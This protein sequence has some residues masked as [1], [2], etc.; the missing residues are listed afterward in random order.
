M[1]SPVRSLLA[2]L[3][4]WSAP[5]AKML[6][7]VSSQ[8][9]QFGQ[10]YEVSFAQ[11]HQL[12]V[13]PNTQFIN[14]SG[15]LQTSPLAAMIGPVGTDALGIP[16]Q[17]VYIFSFSATTEAL[18]L[19]YSFDLTG[20]D[21]RQ[22]GCP[23]FMQLPYDPLHPEWCLVVPNRAS[24][25]SSGSIDIIRLQP[26]GATAPV[27]CNNRLY[28][29][30][31]PPG[32]N[33][34]SHVYSISHIPIVP[35]TPYCISTEYEGPDG[36]WSF[37][38]LARF[39]TDKFIV[40]ATGRN[41]ILDVYYGNT[42][43]SNPSR[44]CESQPCGFLFAGEHRKLFLSTSHN[45][46]V[47]I[48]DR[49][50]NDSEI[51]DVI[52]QIQTPQHGWD[53]ETPGGIGE[54]GDTHRAVVLEGA[55][56]SL[57]GL[58]GETRL[59]FFSNNTMGFCIYDISNPTSPQFVWQWDGDT[60]EPADAT[61]AWDWCGTITPIGEGE[62]AI[63]PQ[64]S[65]YP[66]SAFG[67]ELVYNNNTGDIRL[68]LGDCADGLLAFDLSYFLNPFNLPGGNTSR[69]FDSISE[70][71]YWPENDKPNEVCGA[72]DTRVL[73][74]TGC[75][76]LVTSWML[77][78]SNRIAIS[79]HRITGGEWLFGRA[80][81][82]NAQAPVQA[83][84]QRDFTI[85]GSSSNPASEA[86]SLS[87]FSTGPQHCSISVFDLSGR[88]VRNFG[89]DL[90]PGENEIV[91][92]CRGGDGSEVPSGTYLIRVDDEY[93]NEIIKKIAVL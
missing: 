69:C 18:T 70:E 81:A 85:I 34:L 16:H 31:P 56:F 37:F 47:V 93:G 42:C 82:E 52:S 92:D 54:L 22:L 41:R 91:W 78:V 43:E 38:G 90:N 32:Y 39:V 29:A 59:L 66:G 61:G 25:D 84:L 30:S 88:V 48:W 72:L 49:T 27:V 67:I 24:E 33:R 8:Y 76:Y 17:S 35:E 45:G 11:V 83:L 79:V 46:G 12:A 7:F 2:I 40:D 68:F 20:T 55:D 58:A 73:D 44:P 36:P 14:S 51:A 5:G 63:P 50:K 1:P 3:L 23:R 74:C 86:F 21:G 77:P 10:T 53:Q 19:Q 13:E 4:I 75:D 65:E 62:L 89:I 60:R 26:Q 64:N 80:E 28:V 87:V 9:L 57:N 6:D 71:I 15:I